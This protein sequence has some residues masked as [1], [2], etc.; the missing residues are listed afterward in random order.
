MKIEVSNGEIVDKLTILLIKKENIEDQAKLRNIE[1]EISSI[2]P[3]SDQIIKRKDSMFTDLY[4]V[5]QE[6]WDIEDKIRIMEK[7]KRFDKEFIEV[8]RSVYQLNDKRADIKRNINKF[9]GS[10]LFEEK[11]YEGYTWEY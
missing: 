10:V 1:E 7:E 5:N 3:I 8:A 11:S 6:L 4:K 9:S 2:A